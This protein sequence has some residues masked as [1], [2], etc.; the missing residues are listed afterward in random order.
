M[1]IAYMLTSLGMG[2]AERQVVALAE[3]M[4]ARS[5]AVALILLRER[6]PEEWPT[7]V[8]LV[9][10]EMR[11][12]PFS[13]IAGLLRARR[14]LRDFQPELIHSHV[15]P[16]NMAARLLK[17]SLPAAVLST[18]HNVYE[19]S[20]PRMLAYRLTD[21]LSRRTAFVSQAAAE[22]YARLK[23]VPARKASVLAN[24]IDLAEFAPS[25]ERR[26]L[27]RAQMS[28]GEEFVWLA[29]GRI[30]PAKDFPNLL[31]AF[32]RVRGEFPEARLWIAGDALR[33]GSEAIQA[34]AAE[35]GASVRWLGLCRDM[36]ALLDAADGFV[37]ASAWEGMPLALGEAMAM[38][39][40]VVA[41]DV[42]GVRELVGEAG[43][44]VPAKSPD[45]LAEAML[46]MMRRTDDERQKLG[47]AA[48]ERIAARFSIDAKAD[49]WEALYRAVLESEQ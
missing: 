23:A 40:P 8:D 12:T 22:R 38:A 15:F 46:D 7:T 25:A 24:G 32:A 41:T 29:A 33:A 19:G 13:F 14:W 26:G 17:F 37:L 18:V 5:H 31:R 2:G 10:L 3:R 43:V 36:P 27:I 44:I 49:E 21:G 34:Q 6:Q 9:C 4:K 39:K 28:V 42:G 1:R 48:R 11:K 20:W 45:T 35:L 16:A 30:V 47:V